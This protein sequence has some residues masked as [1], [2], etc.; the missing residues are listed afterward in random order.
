MLIRYSDGSFIDGVIHRLEGGTLRAAVTGLEDAVE[1]RL[2]RDEWVSESGNAVTFEFPVTIRA[3]LI[4]ILPAA[5]SGGVGHC[6]V[7]GDC[8]LRRMSNTSTGPLN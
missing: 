2:I 5:G 6:A 1:F 3:E 4:D 8:L 7:G